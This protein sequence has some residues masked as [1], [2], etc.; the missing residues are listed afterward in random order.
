MFTAATFISY[1]LQCYVPVEI[2]WTNYLT[3]RFGGK[4]KWE[5]VV[6]ISIVLITCKS[7]CS[8]FN[9]F[10]ANWQIIFSSI[11]SR[12]GNHCTT[13]RTVHFFGGRHVP[14]DVGN[15]IPGYYGDLRSVPGQIGTIQCGGVA[16]CTTHH[17]R[18][19]RVDLRHR[20]E[21][22]RHHPKFSST[23]KSCVCRRE[24]NGS[25]SNPLIRSRCT[26]FDEYTLTRSMLM[27]PESKHTRIFLHFFEILFFIDIWLVDQYTI[28]IDTRAHSTCPMI[29]FIVSC[30]HQSKFLSFSFFFVTR[31]QSFVNSCV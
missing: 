30:T 3:K 27:D 24:R 22:G 2:I 19:R 26:K 23:S 16:Q 7:L 31:P 8:S 17:H 20:Q 15:N 13:S 4:L 11:N 29:W 9:L 10:D 14:I 21:F 6:R 28:Y 5:F 1:G 12:S 25:C 18:F